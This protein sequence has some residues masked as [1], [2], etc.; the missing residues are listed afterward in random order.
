MPTIWFSPT[1]YASGEP[2]FQL[3]YPSGTHPG[4]Y[5][6]CTSPGDHTCVGVRSRPAL[7]HQL[8]LAGRA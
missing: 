6:T 5:V 2:T 3:S 7:V 1:E 8:Y 4:T